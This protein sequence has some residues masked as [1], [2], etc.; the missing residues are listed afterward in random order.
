[1]SVPLPVASVTSIDPA[2]VEG[3]AADAV[4]LEELG[5]RGLAVPTAL[6]GG[7][8]EGESVFEAV[9]PGWLSRSFSLASAERPAAIR[10]GILFDAGQARELAGLLR[11]H[12]GS[13]IV[14]APLVRAGGRR[15]LDDA[16][17]A[18]WRDS[19]LPQGHVLVLRLGDLAAF[20]GPHGEE[21]AAILEAA[22][23]VEGVRAVLVTGVTRQGRILDLLVE[24]GASAVFDVP[25]VSAPR[26]DGLAGAHAAALAAALAHGGTLSHAARSA[27]RY[28]GMRL[29]RR[30]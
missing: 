8:G 5:C 15:I 14:L 3:I 26:L 20:S 17:L 2:G 1:M 18:A 4:V 24:E 16:A 9:P 25:R 30:R 27:Q 12:G 29:Q 21:P 19:L 6:F 7:A 11:L 10:V 28:V 22:A 23:R 13:R